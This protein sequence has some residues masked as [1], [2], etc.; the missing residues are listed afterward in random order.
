MSIEM[1][2]PKT[3]LEKADAA[4]NLV[5]QMMMFEKIGDHVQFRRVHE[6]AAEILYELT[7]Q[8][9]E[10]ESCQDHSS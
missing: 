4:A 10:L 5:G 6:R 2:N 1:K 9:V 7:E 3:P 8:L